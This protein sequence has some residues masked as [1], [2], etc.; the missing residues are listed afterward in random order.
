MTLTDDKHDIQAFWGSLYDSLYGDSDQ[1]IT[2]DQ[3][4]EAIDAMEDMFRLRQHM[5][6]VEMPLA[7]LAGKRVL[8]IGPGAGG[9]SAL[10]ARHGAVVTAVDITQARARATAKKFKI[11]EADDC[12][13][14][15]GDAESL[16]FDD[17]TFDIV[18][19]NG[20]LHHTNDSAKAIDEVYRV[21]KPGGRAVIML[22]C[23][24]SWHYWIN[25]L[26]CVGVLKGKLLGGKNW[27]GR[28]T[29]W[30]GRDSQTV[31][32]PVTRCYTAGGIRGLFRRFGYLTLRKG[33]F[34][35]YL[36]PKLGQ[37]YRRW[38]IKR[39][40]THP[41]GYLVY[42]EPWPIQSPLEGRLG[43]IMGFAWFISATKPKNNPQ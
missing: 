35:F 18:Y 12:E 27:L 36:I 2:R 43:R 37:I 7:D 22:Y 40:G 15:Q 23:K 38:Q 10:F 8:E 14:M 42:G 41:G 25:M 1:D 30:G 31:E 32:N 34:Y 6:V 33:E 17:G 39:Y 20:V 16:T 24:S 29:E 19:S 3:L 13:A 5:A 26:L 11:L 9:H 28:A 4:L 21:L